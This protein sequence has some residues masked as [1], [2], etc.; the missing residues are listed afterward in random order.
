MKTELHPGESLVKSSGA[1][2][3]RGWETVGGHLHLT[4]QR[5]IF[6]GHKFNAQSGISEIPVAELASTE[7]A[8]TKFL[9]LIPLVPNSLAVETK[10]GASYRFVLGG[11]KMWKGLLDEVI[12]A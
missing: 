6:E 3:Q 10:D 8:W 9:G 4:D 5:L 1:N 7:L 2:L 11:R 12:A